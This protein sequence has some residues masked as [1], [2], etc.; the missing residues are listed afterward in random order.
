MNKSRQNLIIVLAVIFAVQALI[1]VLLGIFS[2][3][4][5]KNRNVKQYLLKN[6]RSENVAAIK[7]EDPNHSFTVEKNGDSQWQVLY[8]GF[9]L[10]A[11]T[12]QVRDYLGLLQDMT[13]GVVVSS[14]NSDEDLETYGFNQSSKLVVTI[15]MKNGKKHTINVGNPGSGRGSSY[16][17]YN[18]EKKI[19]E[20]KSYISTQ[21]SN[22]Y[23]TWSKK[24]IL[25]TDIQGKD[26]KTVELIPGNDWELLE[27]R[28]TIRQLPSTSSGQEETKT[29]FET[30]PAPETGEL[31]YDTMNTM[32]YNIIRFSVDDYKF[33][34]DTAGKEKAASI[35][36]SL[37]SGQVHEIDFYRADESDPGDYIM[38]VSGEKF[39]YLVSEGTVRGMIMNLD[40]LVIKPSE[41]N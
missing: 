27:S 21:T 41:A 29:V 34:G 39:L 37:M 14:G 10:P 24:R 23:I 18:K 20:I 3:Q 12:L 9:T 32:V 15:T 30:I 11:D 6:F 17:Q 35:K 4:N 33:N 1:I 16:I 2:S 13:K 38:K 36:L 22:Q 7:I 5:M 25:G 19:R 8:N 26:V 40:S 31:N 28:Y